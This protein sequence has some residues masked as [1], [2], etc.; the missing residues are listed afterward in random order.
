MGEIKE[1]GN[2]DAE[3]TYYDSL[4]PT[5]DNQEYVAKLKEDILNLRREYSKSRTGLGE[6]NLV[7]RFFLEDMAKPKINMTRRNTSSNLK[8][9]DSESSLNLSIKGDVWF[10]SGRF[11]D[12]GERMRLG[13]GRRFSESRVERGKK[14]RSQEFG[15]EEKI[16]RLK[17]ST[18][19]HRK[20]NIPINS[21]N[22]KT[23]EFDGTQ[24]MY[25]EI[26]E[27]VKVSS[28][29][30]LAYGRERMAAWLLDTRIQ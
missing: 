21:K 18:G 15:G 30:N 28:P 26:M 20:E 17:E 12:S 23:N 2:S 19:F 10:G 11:Q 24:N 5:G 29:A 9:R 13:G 16:M 14:G 4:C 25:K 6:E 3:T 1:E 27:A 7:K 8:D 22:R